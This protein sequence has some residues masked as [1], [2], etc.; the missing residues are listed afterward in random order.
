MD[1]ATGAAPQPGL[2]TIPALAVPVLPT[3]APTIYDVARIAGLSIASVSRVLNGQ[4]NPRADTRQRV[5]DA[6]EELGFVPDGAA[7]A[8]SA[9]PQGG[10]RSSRPPTAGP[11]REHVRRRG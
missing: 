7:R 10:H 9:R 2:S 6:V 1:T 5:L 8:L 3:Q 4:G 11:R